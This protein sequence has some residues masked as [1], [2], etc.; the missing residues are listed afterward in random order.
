MAFH[1]RRH[2]SFNYYNAYAGSG[3]A[4][5]GI[6]R[7]SRRARRMELGM[8]R[9]ALRGIN[10]TGFGVRRRARLNAMLR[11][12]RGGPRAR[13]LRDFIFSQQ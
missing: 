4:Y 2:R 13:L 11:R 6:Y 7:R 12:R 3:L 9:R 8:Y 5:R 10:N 1:G